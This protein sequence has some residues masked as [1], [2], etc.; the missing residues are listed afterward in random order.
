FADGT[1]AG[2]PA[3]RTPSVELAARGRAF[4]A[5]AAGGVEVL[6]PV[7]GLAGG[8]AVVR[9]YVPDGAMHPGVVR[10][11]TVLLLLGLA[12]FGLGLVVAQWL[13]RRLVGSVTDLARTADRLAQGDLTARVTP[14]GPRELRSV[15]EELNR[16]AARIGE[17]LTAE[18][19]DVADLAH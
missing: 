6:T 3:A 14:D 12:I 7:Q 4:T 18:R 15:G 11:W 19:E 17:L 8:T 13:G 1:M 2:A 5:D 9:A 10:T 16:L